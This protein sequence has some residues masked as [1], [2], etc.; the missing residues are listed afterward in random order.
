MPWHQEAM[1]DVG[2]CEKSRWAVSGVIN[3]EYPNGETHQ[4]TGTRKG[5]NEGKWNISVPSGK[6]IKEIPLVVAS[7]RGTGQTSN[8]YLFEG[9]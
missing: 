3:R 5:A 8:I 7:E 1:K 4:F 6:E 9:L 2:N